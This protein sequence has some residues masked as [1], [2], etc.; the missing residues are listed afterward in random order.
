[1][2]DWYNSAVT[3]RCTHVRSLS[4]D[5]GHVLTVPLLHG[6]LPL[7]GHRERRPRLSVS[8]KGFLLK[9]NFALLPVFVEIYECPY[10]VAALQLHC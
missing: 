2:C 6:P 4:A 10:N 7:Q 3:A 5:E 8:S 9:E 1:M